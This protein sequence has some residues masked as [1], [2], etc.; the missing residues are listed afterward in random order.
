MTSDMWIEHPDVRELTSKI[1]IVNRWR[2]KAL[3]AAHHGLFKTLPPM[4]PLQCTRLLLARLLH[5]RW[6]TL[7][8]TYLRD[9]LP[10][11]DERN[12]NPKTWRC[13]NLP[14]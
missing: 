12:R 11:R 13:P 9:Y 2:K 4:P 5:H 8:L 7:D 1:G 10:T 3:V 14:I 6:E